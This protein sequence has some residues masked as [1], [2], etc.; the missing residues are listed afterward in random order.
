MRKVLIASTGLS[1]QVIT[2]TVWSLCRRDPPWVPDEIRAITTLRGMEILRS[3]LLRSD[4]GQLGALCRELDIPVIRFSEHHVSVL[5]DSQHQ[6]L[7]DLDSSEELHLAA[8]TI[9]GVVR[10]LTA[11]PD[12]EL[13][14]SLGGGRKTLGFLLGYALSL[15]GRDQDRLSHVLVTSRFESHPEFFFPPADPQKLLPVRAGDPV[16]DTAEAKVTLME[17]PFVRLRNL[18]PDRVLSDALTFQESVS[19]A[20]RSLELLELQLD[21]TTASV[22]INHQSV[23]LPTADFVFLLWLVERRTAKQ[24]IQCPAFGAPDM[25]YGEEFILAADNLGLPLTPRT[26]RALR[27][28]M[29]ESFFRERLSRLRLALRQAFGRR[30][31]SQLFSRSS[32][33][34][35]QFG[36]A[37]EPSQVTVLTAPKES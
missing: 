32:G 16:L 37:V 2:E 26:R 33:R 17:I 12:T 9:V 30:I 5:V 3:S 11:D 31:E 18:L 34:P 6:V 7:S 22:R 35:T 1:P 36:L 23:R 20:R 19:E 14:V 15:F 27:N 13:H 24:V 4:G 8:D 21:P 10:Q 25:Q 29:E 28:G